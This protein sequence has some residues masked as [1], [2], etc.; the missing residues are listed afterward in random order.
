MDELTIVK[1]DNYEE[2]VN[3]DLIINPELKIG[4]KE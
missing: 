3:K 2:M 1:D 4:E